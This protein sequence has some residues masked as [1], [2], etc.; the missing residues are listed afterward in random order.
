MPKVRMKP[1]AADAMQWRAFGSR[2]LERKP[3]RI[4]FVA[5]RVRRGEDCRLDPAHPLAPAQVRRQL[6]E[7][8][9]ERF[10]G[11]LG[12]A[13]H[14]RGRRGARWRARSARARPRAPPG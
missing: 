5:A 14:V 8:A 10:R 4:S 6:G 13:R 1:T 3:P 7:L 2:L 12:P 11:R 9:I